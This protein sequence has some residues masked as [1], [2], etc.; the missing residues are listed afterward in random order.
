MWFLV[1]RLL[2]LFSELMVSGFGRPMQLLRS[3][4][5]QFRGLAVFVRDGFWTYRQRGHESGC[6]ET[7]VVRICS[8]SHSLYV[9]GVD[10]NPALS[11]KI[12]YCLTAMAKMQPVDRKASFMFVGDV[13]AHHEEL[14]GSSTTN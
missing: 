9:F 4:D 11:D 5:D 3:E 13:N 7:I 14:L 8:S 1:L 6:C 2:S 10:R 12:F